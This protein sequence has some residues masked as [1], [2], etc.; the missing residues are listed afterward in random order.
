M[1]I[2][3][4]SELEKQLDENTLKLIKKSKLHLAVC[5]EPYLTYML[6]EE[7]N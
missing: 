4:I 1:Y 6:E 5:V 3:I 7:N 2:Q